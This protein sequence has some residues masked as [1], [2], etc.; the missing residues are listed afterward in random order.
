MVESPSTVPIMGSLAAVG[1][2]FS[3]TEQRTTNKI[4]TFLDAP[5]KPVHMSWIP[6]GSA[7]V[8]A[9]LLAFTQ[10]GLDHGTRKRSPKGLSLNW[11]DHT[12]DMQLQVY[13]QA[14]ITMQDSRH[15][16]PYVDFA[17]PSPAN[18]NDGLPAFNNWTSLWIIRLGSTIWPSRGVT[19]GCCRLGSAITS[20][21]ILGLDLIS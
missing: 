6:S 20:L 18:V 19:E 8:E 2:M 5:P 9:L 1:P 21:T 14:H 15:T 17:S 13:S 4:A 11:C 10:E 7:L 12:Y 16:T 3:A